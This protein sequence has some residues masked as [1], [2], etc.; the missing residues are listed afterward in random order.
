MS[1]YWGCMRRG[2]G[3]CKVKYKKHDKTQPE[4]S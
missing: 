4:S 1:D 3:G 2:D